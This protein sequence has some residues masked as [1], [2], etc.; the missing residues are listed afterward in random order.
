MLR[1]RTMGIVLVV[2][3]LSAACGT[4]SGGEDQAGE[5]GAENPTSS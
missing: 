1:L 5:T 2:M 3:L 4:P